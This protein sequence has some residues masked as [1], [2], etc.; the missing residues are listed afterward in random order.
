MNDTEEQFIQELEKELGK[1]REKENIIAEYKHHVY[2]LIEE[3]G[4]ATYQDLV[5]HLGTPREIAKVWKQEHGVTPKKTQWLF[6]L[7]NISI[8]IGGTLLT[9]SYHF[10]QW[11]WIRQ[12]WN[13]LTEIPFILMII[14]VLFWGLLGY[15]IGREFGHRGFRLLKNTFLIAI[16]PNIIL[17][18][19]V[20]FKI[21]PHEWFGSLLNV[22]FII[23]CILFTGILYPVSLLGYRWG[24][25]VS[26]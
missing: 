24:K 14:Y 6:V 23:V 13:G 2:E 8:F 19:L 20:V 18:Y 9:I 5:K 11:N 21:L 26:V 3:N 10:F 25:K 16:I 7:L 12:L 22:P 1:Y 17:M 4:Q 15:E